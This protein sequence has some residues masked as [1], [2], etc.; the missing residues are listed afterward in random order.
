MVRFVQDGKSDE[1][2][3]ISLS[4]LSQMTVPTVLKVVVVEVE[5][6]RGT[7]MVDNYVVP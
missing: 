5:V 6:P 7:V 2:K 3:T 1:L 4:P